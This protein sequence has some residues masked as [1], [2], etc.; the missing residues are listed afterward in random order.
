MFMLYLDLDELDVAFRGSR[1]W[2]VDGW[3]LANIRRRD[4]HG[5]ANASLGDSI[6]ELVA[7]KSGQ[8][9]DGPIRLLTMP[10]CFG[11]RFNPVSFYY[12]YAGDGVELRT[13]VAEV[14]NTPWN[15]QH[16]YVLDASQREPGER[17]HRHRF[18]KQFHV[19]PFMDMAQQYDWRFSS[20]DDRLNVFME[21]FD[22]GERLFDASMSLRRRE[23]SPSALRGLLLRYPLMAIRI[24]AAIYTQAARLW[25]KRAPFFPHPATKADLARK[26]V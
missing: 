4:H 7:T 25:W 21:N 9:P 1:L 17:L 10:S 6:R 11:Y 22:R 26:S 19:S 13:I 14:N 2:S 24:V 5:S 3:G 20:P 12:C 8:R 23:I 15:E 18:A 16:C